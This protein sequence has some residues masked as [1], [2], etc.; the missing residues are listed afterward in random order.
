MK[1]IQY[2][3]YGG[4]D[5]MNMESV[6]LPKLSSNSDVLVKV[7]AAGI[8]ELDW[9]IRNGNL[10]IQDGKGFPKSMGCELAGEVLQVGTAVDSF[11]DGDAVFGWIPFNQ[12]G[13]FAEYVVVAADKLQHKPANLSYE[14]A[15]ALPM[16][17]TTALQALTKEVHLTPEKQVLING[18]TGG[19]GHFAVQIAS[20]TGAEVTAVTS[21]NH[22]TF[23]KELGA[24]NVI[25]Y[26][27]VD[28]QETSDRYDVILDTSKKLPWE[29]AKKLLKEEGTYIDLQPG[30]KA[31][32]GS[33]LQNVFS[34]KTHDVLGVE[35]GE[36]DL[37]ELSELT[38]RGDLRVTVGKV[39][40]FDEYKTALDALEAGKTN[41]IGKA[42]FKMTDA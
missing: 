6:E 3:E 9:K 31:F 36:E 34:H 14:Q 12:L 35:V 23:A 21:T 16:L 2:Y 7:Y 26:H 8:N 37:K 17:G 11:K 29:A 24:S 33:F 41:G 15:A 4:S 22:L 13:A 30:L 20:L 27:E 25:D 5:V 10:K 32:I 40:H 38:T 42:V 1:K 18:A 28:I 39:F 19:V